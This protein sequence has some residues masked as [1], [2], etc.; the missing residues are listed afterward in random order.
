MK[1]WDIL[2]KRLSLPNQQYIALAY[3]PTIADISYFPFAIPWT[4]SFP[5]VDLDQYPKSKHGAKKWL[6][7][8]LKLAPTSGY[9]SIRGSGSDWVYYPASHSGNC[10]NPTVLLVGIYGYKHEVT[11]TG[12]GCIHFPSV[13]KFVTT[14]V[15]CAQVMH[16]LGGCCTTTRQEE[17]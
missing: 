3:R 7:D 10:C 11:H 8:Q 6:Q 16:S 1:Q 9:R 4:C 12:C 17:R 13:F 14:L 2:E 15:S 5:D